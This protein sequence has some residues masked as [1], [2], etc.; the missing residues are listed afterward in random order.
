MTADDYQIAV[1]GLGY[2]GLPLAALCAKK[3]YSVSGFDTNQDVVE[4]LSAGRAPI[5][6]DTIERLLAAAAE[7]GNFRV[8]SNVDE[9]AQANL[10]LI[11]VPTPVDADNAQAAAHPRSRGA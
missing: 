1:V 7:S 11:C 3:G 8:T 2:V 4:A 9:I 10:Y 6:D 5:R